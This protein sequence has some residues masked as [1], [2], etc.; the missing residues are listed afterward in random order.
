MAK[1]EAKTN[2]MRMLEK[3]GIAYTAHEYECDGFMDGIEVA[4]RL[5]LAHEQIYKTLVTTGADRQ[6][7]VFVIPVEREL[8]L[9]KCAKAVGVKSVQMLPVKELFAMTGYVRGGC[10]SVGM[11]KQ[12]AT[13]IDQ[14]AAQMEKIYVSAGRLG[15]QICL[16][17]KDLCLAAKAEFADLVQE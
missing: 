14:S 5:G 10:T 1:K 16:S 3:L 9:K 4:D 15:C 17:P 6:H 7:Y 11:K 2:A 12:F 8:D 13:R